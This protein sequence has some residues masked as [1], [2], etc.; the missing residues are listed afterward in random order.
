MQHDAG[1]LALPDGTALATRRW[2]PGPRPADARGA[3][4]LVHGIGEHSGRYAYVAARLMLDGWA[5]YAYDHRHHGR[6]GGT[7]GYVESVEGLAEDLG[8]V[9][10]HV[11]GEMKGKPVFVLGHSMGGL[12][13]G[14]HVVER[15][16][17]GWAGLILSSAAL[18]IPPTLSPFLQRMAGVVAR[19]APRLATRRLG[20]DALARNPAVGRAYEEDPLT[21]SGGIRAQSGF[22]IL[23]ATAKLRAHP[24]AFTLPLY[25]FHGTDDAITDPEGSKWLFEHA[26]TADKALKLY[27][28]GRHETM[29]DHGKEQVLDDLAMWLDAHAPAA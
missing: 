20:P 8:H 23:Q 27:P 7:L 17:E 29:N 15:G 10:A 13:A 28:E 2:L 12:V 4:L 26:P 24:E 16:H 11:R 22:A 18:A 25:L 5:V 1:L 3:V 14:L 9:V 6:T 19:F 21:Y